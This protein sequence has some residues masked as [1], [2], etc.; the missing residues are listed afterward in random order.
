MPRIGAIRILAAISVFLVLTCFATCAHAHA[1]L[2]ME[3][4]YG[5][6]G[7]VFPTGHSALYFEQVCAE[8]PVKLRRCRPDE[9]GSVITR[10]PGIAG[11]DWV[12]IPLVPYLYA[13]ETPAEVPAHADRQ[14]VWRMRLRYHERHLLSLGQDLI[15]GDLFRGG[16]ALLVGMSYERRIYAFSFETSA[17]QDDALI[18]Q[19]N[20]GKNRSHFQY[21]YNNCSDFARIVLNIYFPHSFRRNLFVDAGI[22]T[23]KSIT[24]ELLGYSHKHPEMELKVFEIPQVPGM[25]RQSKP[26]KGITES[27][28]T[29]AYAIPIAAFNPY[30]AGGLFL[31]YLVRGR[32]HVVPRN[33]Q[34]LAP[35]NLVALTAWLP[36]SH[37]S[38][39]V[40]TQAAGAGDSALAESNASEQSAKLHER[41][42]SPEDPD[43]PLP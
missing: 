15:A 27:L 25:R 12:A 42:P 4:P 41:L 33:H 2:L 32:F 21:L 11:Y 6:F 36:A 31:D 30:V 28:A 34:V 5:F 8:T 35:D 22:T 14:A 26:N 20:A 16:W 24:H 19:F 13:V 18:A 3:E 38:R 43:S 7:I 17:A 40:R 23:P 29:T 37:D 9:L 1:V 39:S 10:D